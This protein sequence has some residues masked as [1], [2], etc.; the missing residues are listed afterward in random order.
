MKNTTEKSSWLQYY[1]CYKE[2]KEKDTN[3]SLHLEFP[4]FLMF[5]EV[6]DSFL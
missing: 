1:Q 2:S 3:E 6:N 4:M 5:S